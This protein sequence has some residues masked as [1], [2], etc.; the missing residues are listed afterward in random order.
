VAEV[1]IG[2]N[3][4]S[5]NVA[6]SI[7]QVTASINKMG[8]AVAAA[9]GVKFDPVDTKYAERDLGRINT[10]FQQALKQ[11]AALR[12]AINN[13][14]QQGKGFAQI[15]W[16]RTSIDPKAAQRMRDRAFTHSTSGTAWDMTNF[17]AEDAGPGSRRP[18]A[19]PD[20]RTY[21]GRGRTREQGGVGRRVGSVVGQAAGGFASGV[22]GVGGHVVSEGIRGASDG[23]SKALEEGSSLMGGMAKGA[24]IAMAISA[25]VGIAAEAGKLLSEGM[26]MAK[27]RNLD[28][29]NIKRQMG[30]LGVSF[31]DLREISDRASAG[32][33]MN[34]AEFAKL[35]QT[36]MTASHGAYRSAG[37]LGEATQLSGGFARSY[38]M[39]PSQSAGFFGGMANLRDP[40]QNNK[41]LAVM[42]AEA[43]Q[44]VGG[45]AMPG[46]V[47][48]A[49]LAN[50]T[51]T[52]RNSLSSANSDAFAGAY[53]GMLINGGPGMNSDTA[54]AI[55]GQANSAMMQGG[56]AGEAGQNFMLQALNA[57][58]PMMNPVEARALEA[59]G[60]FASRGTAF[61]EG[62]PLAQYMESDGHGGVDKEGLA[63]MQRLRGHDDESTSTNFDA[64]KK[65]LESDEPNKWL[66]LDAAQRMMGL[67][68][69]EQASALLNL[70]GKGYGA[71]KENLGSAG[72][73]LDD[74]NATGIQTE[75]QISGA[76]S[77]DELSKVYGDIRARTGAGSLSDDEK[78]QLDTAQGG[79]AADFKK[80]LTQIM[81]GKEQQE[82]VASDGRKQTATLEN[83]QIAIGEKLVPIAN[84]IRGLLMSM[85]GITSKSSTI[86]EMRHAS[87]VATGAAHGNG[88]DD[89]GTGAEHWKNSLSTGT[90]TEQSAGAMKQLQGMG[91]TKNQAA[92]LAA[93][94]WTES[95][96]NPG[97]VGDHGQ[98]YGIGQWHAD[99]QDA[100]KKFMGKDIHGSSLEEQLKFVNYELTEGSE[101]KAGKDLKATTT[102]RA[103]GQ[104]GSREYERPANVEGE[105]DSRGNMADA[106]AAGTASSKVPGFTPDMRIIDKS[107][108]KVPEE[109]KNSQSKADARGEAEYWNAKTPEDRAATAA[110]L[111]YT[112]AKIPRKDQPDGGYKVKQS[113]ERG[114]AKDVVVLDIN[115]N[116][117]TGS[118][119]GATTVHNINT[120]VTV[121]RGTGTQQVSVSN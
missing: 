11:S 77:K 81:A 108:S 53:T 114:G 102:A 42:I 3:A 79:G 105:A 119:N 66:R 50:A 80:L 60:L 33:G 1:K 109:L 56:M 87:D 116:T 9:S 82:T 20:S 92:G 68:S 16:S 41:E 71:L 93:N 47:M 51:Q 67:S 28:L 104:V 72:I 99:R 38:G 21:W 26:D 59:G 73:S 112:P 55:L 62:T 49:V 30:D 43:I 100:F 101:R 18:G 61:G 78:R 95:Q 84:D 23:A 106:I 22:G 31:D 34:A 75:A 63:E 103:A 6:R 52:S 2:V 74:L 113:T 97:A 111:G 121:P 27:A 25:V 32:L 117:K 64:F 10:Q 13:S 54:G 76:N 107:S 39:D 57:T 86:E 24:G 12:N 88:S 40:R 8:A 70:D 36:Q 118:Q 58:G 90:A 46:D 69:P 83:I 7:D 120:S 14:G 98:A 115:L 91:W 94:L 96:M 37:E 45:H 35:E 15:D 44:R 29:D 85:A 5:G 19:R 4:N 65:K 17:D 48:Q 89:D 110:A